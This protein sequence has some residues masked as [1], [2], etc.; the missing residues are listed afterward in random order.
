[1]VRDPVL[2]GQRSE[3]VRRA[4][5][6]AIVR[7]LH[8]NGPLSRSALVARTGLTRTAIRA[9]IGDL[10]A[11]GFVRED[12]PVAIGTPG[13]PSPLVRLVPGR[14]VVLAI[15]IA[16]DSLAVA[17]VGLGGTVLAIE[18]IDRLRGRT[19]AESV[20]A[21]LAAVVARI[22]AGAPRVG[23]IG[24]AAAVAGVVRRSDGFVSTAPNLDWRDE[25]LGLRLSQ[26]L[27]LGLPIAVAN[28]ADLGALAEHRRGAARGADHVLF[29]S[30]DV[31]V[32]GGLIV[33]GVPMTGVAGYGG[34]IGHLPL[35][36]HGIACGC[37]SIGC[38]E[39]EVGAAAL[40]RRAG[41]PADGGR[42]EIDIVMREAAEGSPRVLEALDHIGHWLG[43]G[44]AGLVNTFNPSLIVLGGLVGRIHPW[45]AGVVEAELDRRA[46]AAPR[47]LV[48]IV[49]SKLG[50][51]APLLGAGELAFEPVL[52]DPAILAGPREGLIQLVSA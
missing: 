18:R 13:R 35:N 46:L 41:H 43:I 30:G 38:W 8:A 42:P 24:A 33:D 47:G 51:D 32:G 20:V 10:V 12:R 17:L 28:E 14:A 2:V 34:E 37:G 39:T 36:P 21:D 40:L 50:V 25:P 9:L 27:D 6:S 45:V 44:L 3:T 15:E 49:P 4:N 16:V 19:D 1:M 22:R 26:V 52:A 11:A 23:L 29:V 7:E 5:L 31:G 48:R